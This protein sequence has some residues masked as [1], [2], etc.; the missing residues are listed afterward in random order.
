MLHGGWTSGGGPISFGPPGR[1]LDPG[2][3]IGVPVDEVATARSRLDY[4]ILELEL[5]EEQ[6]SQA[7]LTPNE[8]KC[9]IP[10]LEKVRDEYSNI[11]GLLGGL[12]A[13][14]DKDAR[15]SV[16]KRLSAARSKASQMVPGAF[17]ASS[18]A[19][20]TSQSGSAGI[21]AKLPPINLP[22][23]AGTTADWIKW[24]RAFNA[25]V[26]SRDDLT[27]EAKLQYLASTVSG[28]ALRLVSNAEAMGA[29]YAT[30]MRHLRN[31]FEDRNLILKHYLQRFVSPGRAT[32]DGP[33]LHD[34]LD[35][36]RGS[37]ESLMARGYSRAELFDAVAGHLLLENLPPS[38][39]AA[40]DMRENE[41][42]SY[43]EICRFIEKHAKRLSSNAPANSQPPA[44]TSVPLP[45]PSFQSSAPS[46]LPA[47]SVLPTI[48]AQSSIT[49]APATQ[50]WRHR[51]AP[52]IRE[53]RHIFAMDVRGNCIGCGSSPVHPLHTCSQYRKLDASQ[54]IQLIRKHN[55]CENCLA[56]G[57]RDRDCK[58]RSCKI[59][60]ESHHTTLHDAPRGAAA[61]AVVGSVNA[62]GIEEIF[63]VD[64]AE[65]VNADSE[66]VVASAG[67]GTAAAVPKG[68]PGVAATEADAAPLVAAVSSG[69]IG[70]AS[71]ELSSLLPLLATA[72]I[73]I[74]RADGGFESVRA[75]VGPSVPVKFN[76]W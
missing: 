12:G 48:M 50:T 24:I 35:S 13:P 58:S 37:A 28:E 30:V 36:V 75:L 51:D 5:L 57:H 66:Q 76:F 41:D 31:R 45:L 1:I 9:A 18:G 29:N 4:W 53:K 6:L 32:E 46:A 16:I 33:A 14:I 68:A 27:S 39:K 15:I 47:T 52:P 60:G 59:C 56:P 61:H 73:K 21:Q 2:H 65:L 67:M 25:T 7:E 63:S 74:T 54:R 20:A 69:C 17:S 64:T 42:T 71:S 23:F 11:A 43:A 8:A 62:D 19:Y 70:A 26:D 72:L 38:L 34:L 55:R 40:W 22:I 49:P 3:S 44:G 10:Q